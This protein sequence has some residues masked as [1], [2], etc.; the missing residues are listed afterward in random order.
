M[1]LGPGE[2]SGA[3]TRIF[4]AEPHVVEAA[5]NHAVIHSRLAATYNQARYLPAVRE[6]LQLLADRL[7]GIAAGRADFTPPLDRH[8]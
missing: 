3:D 6:A 5:L 1:R 7:D 4:G 8:A 2:G